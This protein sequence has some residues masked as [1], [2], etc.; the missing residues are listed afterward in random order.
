MSKQYEFECVIDIPWVNPVRVASSEEEFIENILAEY[1]DALFGL[2]EIYR[3]DIRKD[4]IKN[5]G[6]E[7]DE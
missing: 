6:E 1:N 3:C 5:N 4:S 7:D 2:A